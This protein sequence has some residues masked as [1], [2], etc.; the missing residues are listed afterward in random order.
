MI[1]KCLVCQK[2]F[3]PKIRNDNKK[4]GKYCSRVCWAK[5]KITGYLIHCNTCKKPVWTTPSLIRKFCSQKCSS[6]QQSKQIEFICRWCE[7]NFWD[8]PCRMRQG[9]QYCNKQC[10]A[11]WMSKN[12]TGKNSNN[13][14]GGIT[15]LN[16]K[17]RNSL[18]YIAWR[19]DIF[20]RDNYTC[21]I[22][23]ERGGRLRAN[24]I[25]KFSDYPELRTVSANG[26]TICKNCD[27]LLILH[28]EPEWESYFNFNLMTRGYLYG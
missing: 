14:R 3:V 11:N 26:I 13:W 16:H 25:K 9:K 24:H 22:C 1:K 7:K 2:E 17:I 18:E 28:R 19:K 20:N 15:S 4:R 10:K 21:Q 6:I 23:G 5:N 27:I 8:Q 12:L